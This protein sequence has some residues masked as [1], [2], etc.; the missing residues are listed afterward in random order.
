[1]F[2]RF[3]VIAVSLVRCGANALFSLLQVSIILMR[4]GS[5]AVQ[6]TFRALLSDPGSTRAARLQQV[7]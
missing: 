6:R 2:A 3:S 7:W 1:M 4:A 5:D